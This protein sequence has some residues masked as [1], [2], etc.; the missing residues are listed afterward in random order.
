MRQ[1]ALDK[2]GPER[3]FSSGNFNPDAN[4]EG[5]IRTHEAGQPRPRDFQSRSLSHSDTSPGCWPKPSRRAFSTEIAQV[6]RQGEPTEPRL[7][8]ASWKGYFSGV[9]WS[10]VRARALGVEIEPS[11]AVISAIS[12]GDPGSRPR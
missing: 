5:G 3:E 4:G 10:T 9:A 7:G 12:K 8:L 11:A 6:N 2:A 1:A